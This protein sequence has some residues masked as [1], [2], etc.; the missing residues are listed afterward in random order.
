MKELTSV[1]NPLVR[2]VCQLRERKERMARQLTLIDGI[3]EIRSALQGGAALEALYFSPTMIQ[4]RQS[5]E[6][7]KDLL[8]TLAERDVALYQV[9]EPVMEKMAFGDRREG[10]LAVC[11]PRMIRLS[12]LPASKVP[13]YLVIDKVEKPGNLGAMMRLAD[14]AGIDAVLVSDAQTDIFNPNVIRASLGTLFTLPV[15]QDEVQTIADFLKSRGCQI[16]AATPQV[17]IRYIDTNF[18]RPSAIVVGS[19]QQGLGSYWLTHAHIKVSIPMFG[20]ADSLN[21]AVSSAILVYE[22]VR[23]RIVLTTKKVQ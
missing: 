16:I 18:C 15:I 9:S 22:A 13:L 11:R 2:E 8:N 20:Q 1:R 10:I 14:A 17:E 5:G 12:D 23:Q 3:R 4:A 7:V 6:V 19:E 21:V